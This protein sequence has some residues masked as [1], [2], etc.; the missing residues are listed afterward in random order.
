M[1]NPMQHNCEHSPDGW[2]LGC[3]QKQSDALE[4]LTKEAAHRKQLHEAEVADL[5][6]E[7]DSLKEGLD[8]WHSRYLDCEVERDAARSAALAEG[9]RAGQFAVENA[10]LKRAVLSVHEAKGRYHSQIAMC[11]LYDACGLNNERPVK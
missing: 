3:V 1:T 6:A 4:R 2:C 10:A 7:R 8:G 11:D 5:T 9:V